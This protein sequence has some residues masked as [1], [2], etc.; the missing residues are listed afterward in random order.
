M[1]LHRYGDFRVE[2]F[3]FDSPCIVSLKVCENRDSFWCII[4]G[5]S[6]IILRCR[7]WRR[8]VTLQCWNVIS[9]SVLS[10]NGAIS[11]ETVPNVTGHVITFLTFFAL[12]YFLII[13][14]RVAT[15]EFFFCYAFLLLLNWSWSRSYNFGLGLGLDRIVLGVGL[16]L[17]I[18]VLFPS[19]LQA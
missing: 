12:S 6:M 7:A 8:C 19:L 3:Y 15:E 2:V 16:G 5:V 17:N 4:L 9:T 10:C 13:N 18:L 1:A 14:M 11:T